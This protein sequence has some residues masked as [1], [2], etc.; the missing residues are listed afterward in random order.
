MRQADSK[1]M[2]QVMAALPFRSMAFSGLNDRKGHFVLIPKDEDRGKELRPAPP[3]GSPPGKTEPHGARKSA[4]RKRPPAK[5]RSRS[6]ERP[7]P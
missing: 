5:R 4:E 7:Q 6:D 2:D 1:D 3:F